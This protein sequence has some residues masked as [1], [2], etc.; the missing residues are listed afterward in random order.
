MSG[1][2]VVH[3]DYGPGEIT[4]YTY[5]GPKHAVKVRFD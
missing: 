3:D 2:R 4:L 1:K 5:L